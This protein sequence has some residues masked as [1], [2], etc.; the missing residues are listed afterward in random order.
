MKLKAGYIAREQ[1]VAFERL[2]V[3][4][5][6]SSNWKVEWAAQN[7]TQLHGTY[8]QMRPDGT[9]LREIKIWRYRWDTTYSGVGGENYKKLAAEI[10]AI[11]K[12]DA[13]SLPGTKVSPL[14]VRKL[15]REFRRAYHWTVSTENSDGDLM[16][17]TTNWYF[18]GRSA[19]FCFEIIEHF[20]TSSEDDALT[21]WMLNEKPV[22]L[23]AFLESVVLSPYR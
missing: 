6:I 1:Q 17:R 23:D 9:P 4:H 3:D 7:S 5:P 16:L 21:I 11:D 2:I 22:E 19:T 20:V 13:R 12:E 15:S 10:Q 14:R 18:K 8:V